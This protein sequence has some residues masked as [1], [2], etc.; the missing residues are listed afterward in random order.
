ML[1]HWESVRYAAPS[2]LGLTALI[3]AIM[4][5]LYTPASTAL[6]QPQLKF[7]GWEHLVLQGDV[8]A[9]FA[10]ENYLEQNCKTPITLTIDDNTENITTT[11]IEIEHASESFHNYQRWLGDW[12]DFARSGNGTRS[13]ETRPKGWALLMDNTTV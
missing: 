6:V 8:F 4:A 7:G 12:T 10:N 2:L 9:S 3:A 5:M 13:L 1:T 11:C